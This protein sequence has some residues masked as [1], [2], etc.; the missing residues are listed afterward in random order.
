LSHVQVNTG[1]LKPKAFPTG[2]LDA[3][4]VL[5]DHPYTAPW[6]SEN[7]GAKWRFRIVDDAHP[8]FKGRQHSQFTSTTPGK[9]FTDLF[10]RFCNGCGVSAS[11]GFD[12][13][14]LVGMTVT[15]EMDTY[16]SDKHQ[17]ERNSIKNVMKR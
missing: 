11:E 3:E 7:V 10:A 8:D 17:E 14:E 12:S 6:D 4:I 9:P 2:L 15:L 5:F 13:E 1:S 16:W